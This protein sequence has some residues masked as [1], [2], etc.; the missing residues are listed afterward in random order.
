MS[1]L[2]TESSFKKKTSMMNH[3]R[4]SSLL[5]LG[6]GTHGRC[7]LLAVVQLEKAR[8]P[9][10]AIRANA[11]INESS[12]EKVYIGAPYLAT[13]APGVKT[14]YMRNTSASWSWFFA[15][16]RNHPSNVTP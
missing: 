16:P 4:G 9:E 8:N 11:Y 3:K 10:T 6:A 15:P 12:T 2:V 14:K 1:T 7:L 13:R 5:A